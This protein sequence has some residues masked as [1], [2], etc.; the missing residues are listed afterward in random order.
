MEDLLQPEQFQ[1][2]IRAAQQLSFQDPDLA[3]TVLEGTRSLLGGVEPLEKR[4][5]LM[6]ELIRIWAQVEGEVEPK[7]YREGFV[8]VDDLRQGP[9]ASEQTPAVGAGPSLAAADNLERT[10]VAEYARDDFEAALKYIAGLSDNT[11]KLAM[12]LDIVQRF[13]EPF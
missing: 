13:R 6:T 7:L 4:A 8:L 9:R 2:L 1:H 3:S 11:A 12:L 5:Q 10:L